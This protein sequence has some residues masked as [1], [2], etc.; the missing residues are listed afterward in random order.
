MER[1]WCAALMVVS[2]RLGGRLI[3]RLP[4]TIDMLA[5]SPPLSLRDTMQV[6]NGRGLVS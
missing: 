3:P 6:N 2:R 5:A 4:R 1:E